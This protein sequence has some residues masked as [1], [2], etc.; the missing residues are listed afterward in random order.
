M[1]LLSPLALLWAAS[2]PVL[3]W[4]WRLAATRRQVRVPSL[5]PFEHLLKRPPRRRT[6]LV[7][8]LLFWLQLLALALAT[9]ALAQPV[10]F[11]SRAKTVLVVVDTSA[12]MEAA[13]AFERAQQ[14]LLA[15]LARKAPTEQ[16]FLMTTAPVMPATPQPTS[17][18]AVLARAVRAL[19][20]N[21]LGG[22]LATTARIGRSLMGVAPA[23]IL[24]VT[25]E[26]PPAT[27]TGTAVEFVTV[28]QLLANVAIVGLDTRG[29]LCQPAEARVM[30]TMQNFSDES[31]PVTVAAAHNGRRLA[32]TDVT[33]A[34]HARDTLSLA[35]PAGT[36]GLVEIL[37]RAA[38]DGLSVDDR[39]WFDMQRRATLPIV[40]Q[41]R[42]P[43]IGKTLAT[44]LGA[45]EALTWGSETP[46]TGQPFVLITDHDNPLASA[47][48]ASLIVHPP[49]E[50]HPLLS[51][52]VTS[53]AHPIGSYLAPVERVAASLNLTAGLGAA[54]TPIVSGL[55]GGR[56]TPVVVADERDGRRVASLF[57]DPA[58]AED[59]TPVLVAFFNSVRWLMGESQTVTTG[60]PIV[61]SGLRSGSV[62]VRR[63]DGAVDV[64]DA[65]GGIVSYEA[66]TR[67]GLYRLT[68]GS[69]AVTRAVNFFDPLESNLL[70]RPSTWH[71]SPDVSPTARSPQRTAHPLASTLLLL[72]VILVLLEWW[73]YCGKQT[74]GDRPRTTDHRPRIK[75]P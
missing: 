48:S 55:V 1:S 21:H 24:V 18:P 63:P 34:P 29:A 46:S 39:A 26:S 12:S 57:L 17:D 52:W 11:G 60:E 64:I 2:I 71:A 38:R 70:T 53:A 4:L 36:E 37:L 51:Y 44:W 13:H 43:A 59:S 68:Q 14:A 72:L 50:P 3:L 74:T 47:A 20:A 25:D 27:P 69:T 65:P 54:G 66:T 35:I 32:A 7:V 16:W 33:P 42:S 5:V 75:A 49:A 6:H 15:R 30:V 73:R 8:N 31:A 61:I 22:N 45:C 56:K 62:S 19:Q 23:A 67:A 41:T 40:V 9:L 58:G 28:G 10:L